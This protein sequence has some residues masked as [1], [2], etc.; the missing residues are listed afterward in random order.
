MAYVLPVTVLPGQVFK[1]FNSSCGEGKREHCMVSSYYY[2]NQEVV[3][4]MIFCGIKHFQQQPVIAVVVTFSISTRN[5]Q[6]ELHPTRRRLVR[7]KK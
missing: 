3:E 4:D 6:P 7:K 5:A 2:Y 1:F